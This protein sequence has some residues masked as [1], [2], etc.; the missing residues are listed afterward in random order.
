LSGV[1][2]FVL[3]RRDPA[4]ARPFRVPLYPL[5]PLVFCGTCGYLLYASLV[6]T[7]TGALWGVAVLV[8]GGVVLGAMRRLEGGGT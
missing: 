8:V 5:T 6:Y 3:R 2:L 1:S 4:S 7:G